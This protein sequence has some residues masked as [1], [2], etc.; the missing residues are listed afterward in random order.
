MLRVI[1][2]YNFPLKASSAKDSAPVPGSSISMSSY[3]GM[4]WSMDDF[5]T[6]SSGLLVTETSI[7][8]FNQELWSKVSPK[9][10]LYTGIRAMVA[11]RLA[12][13][14]RQWTKLFTLFNSG[15]YNN[16]WMILNYGVFEPGKPL[17]EGL[18][19]ILE[20]LPGLMVSKDVTADLNKNGYWASYNIPYFDDIFQLSGAS[21]MQSKFGDYYSHDSCPRAKIFARDQSKV[22]D[23]DSMMQLMRYNDYQHDPLS[24]CNC[25]P[26]YS[27]IN[28]ISARSE[29]NPEDG[30]YP[31]PAL[32]HR[33]MGA[34]DM[35]LTTLDLFL[36]QQF[37]AIAGPTYD[38]LP[39]FQWSKSSLNNRPHF[40][41]PDKYEFEPIIHQW[42]WL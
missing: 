4:V 12:N 32:G 34:T 37:V 1:K 10:S 2:R 31:F 13:D 25:T 16:Q 21:K 20:Q 29:L 5:Y 18:L 35:K 27:A 40:G 6:V 14:G 26:P 24:R 9:N 41:M 42:K 28:A 30:K 36:L 33:E 38:P 8:N 23:I 7:S 3:P 22:H 19:W 15:T 11:N 17:R 39:P